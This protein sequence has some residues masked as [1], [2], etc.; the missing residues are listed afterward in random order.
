[1]LLSTKAVA[2]VDMVFPVGKNHYRALSFR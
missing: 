2:L 1:L